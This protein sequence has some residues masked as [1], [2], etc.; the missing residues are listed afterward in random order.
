MAQ[1]T[2]CEIFVFVSIQRVR[3]ERQSE[4]PD[5]DPEKREEKKRGET[6]YLERVPAVRRARRDGYRSLPDL[7]DA[8]PVRDGDGRELPARRGGVADF[9]QKRV[10]GGKKEGKRFE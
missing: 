4:N 8:H 1:E 5:L 7:D 9:L 2:A 6:I 10:G 3:R